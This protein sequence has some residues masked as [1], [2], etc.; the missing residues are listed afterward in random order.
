MIELAGRLLDW[1]VP[2]AKADIPPATGGPILVIKSASSPFGDY[3]AEILRAEGFNAFSVADIGAVTPAVLAAADLVILAQTSLAPDQVTMLT[4][5]V[6]AGGNLIS[7]RPGPELAG[8]LGVT[9][10]GATLSEAYLVVDTSVPPGNGIVAETMQFHGT[11]TRFNLNGAAAVATLY[12]SATAAT[13]DPAVTLRTVGASGGQTAAF[14][15][16]LATSIVYTRQGNPAWANQ[17]RDG[18]A[19]QRSDDKYYGN[20]ATDP[21]AD[22]VDLNK[23]AIPQADEQQRLLANLIVQMT[24]DRKPLPRFWYFPRGKKAVVLMTGDDHGNNGTEG[25]WNDFLAASPP[26]CAVENW[27]CVRGTSYMYPSTPMTNAMATAFEAQGFE[28]GLHVSTN[29]ADYTQQELDGFYTQQINAFSI[30]WPSV[31]QPTTQRHHCI[32]WTDWVTAAKVQ[33]NYGVRLD[34]SYYFWPPNWVDNRPGFFN[35][36]GMPMRFADTNGSLIDVYQAATQMTDESGQE[37]PFTI[38]TLLDRA[39][40]AEGYYGA[41]VINAHTDLAVIPESTRTLA[42]AQARN[43]PIITSRQMLQWLDGRSNSSFGAITWDGTTLR[44]NVTAGSGVTGLESMVPM[45]TAAGVVNGVER[46]GASTPY[47]L[48]SRKGVEYASFSAAAGAYGVEQY[49]GNSAQKHLLLFLFCSY[50]FSVLL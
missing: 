33:S 27:E 37:Y 42:S 18:F 17:E 49:L 24:L 44:F 38:D 50:S 4:D 40:G 45:Y 43:V 10:T 14:A 26:G 21:Q 29:C 20:A 6:N 2:V 9:P 5:W 19:P 16:D 36:S 34:T 1:L 46:D 12:T 11:A 31:P 3:Y 22:W 39:L 32:A 28:V 25:R 15:Y 23:V 7:M 47:S 30:K 35:G 13:T 8:L 48:I 41:Y